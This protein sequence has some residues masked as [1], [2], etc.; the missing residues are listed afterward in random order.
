MPEEHQETPSEKYSLR[1]VESQLAYNR[2]VD[3]SHLRVTDSV[4]QNE[5]VLRD[6]MGKW[7]DSVRESHG[8]YSCYG[9]FLILPSDK[10]IIDY[11][12]DYADEL[13]LISG[14]GCLILLVG[15]D[16]L[17]TYNTDAKDILR[18][19]VAQYS[20]RGHSVELG[21]IFGVGFSEFPC[22]ILFE[23]I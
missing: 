1:I 21:R 7:W 3:E 17:G 12:I 15:V 20:V 9:I 8:Q 22:L 19:S 14:R 18:L 2:W 4:E 16:F 11:L 13:H 5:S 10:N 6:R 23:D